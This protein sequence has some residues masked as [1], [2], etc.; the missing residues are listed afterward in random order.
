[1]SPAWLYY[2]QVDDLDG[3]L[4]RVKNSGGKVLNGPVTVPTG[5]R[6]AQVMDPQ[7]AAFAVHELAKK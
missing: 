6:I 7:G 4:V 1:M 5:A 3:T 2:V